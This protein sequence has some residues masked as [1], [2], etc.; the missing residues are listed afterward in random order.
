MLEPWIHR[1]RL[2]ISIIQLERIF[3]ALVKGGILQIL[4]YHRGSKTTKPVPW[5][6]ELRKEKHTLLILLVYKLISMPRLLVLKKQQMYHL[7]EQ[8][9]LLPTRC[10]PK[11]RERRMLV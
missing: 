3:Q 4:M 1:E 9:I 2:A 5:Y 7:R 10:V 6:V 11:I 8:V